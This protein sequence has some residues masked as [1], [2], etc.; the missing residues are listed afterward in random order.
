MHMFSGSLFYS[1]CGSDSNPALL[2]SS[3]TRRPLSRDFSLA[4]AHFFFSRFIVIIYSILNSECINSSEG[5]SLG[6]IARSSFQL[7]SILLRM[8]ANV[9]FRVNGQTFRETVHSSVTFSALYFGHSLARAR[10]ITF[11]VVWLSQSLC[12]ACRIHLHNFLML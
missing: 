6:I 8:L 10:A 4:R 1:T 9:F 11:C 3:G 2:Y 5:D 12:R 7:L